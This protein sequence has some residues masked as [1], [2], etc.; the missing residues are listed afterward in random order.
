MC[1]V[2]FGTRRLAAGRRRGGLAWRLSERE[3]S[4][5]WY[6]TYVVGFPETTRDGKVAI[7]RKYSTY[8]V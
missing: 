2:N 8:G 7:G 4:G 5:S 1:I 6:F 3:A